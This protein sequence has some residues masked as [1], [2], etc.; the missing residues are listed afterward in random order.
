M[1]TPGLGVLATH[2]DLAGRVAAGWS[3]FDGTANTADCNGHGTHVAGT[4]A[5]TTSGVAKAAT[6]VPVR[7]LDC[8]G[9][10]TLS[11]VIAGIDWAIGHHA[12]GVPAL[13]NLSLGGGT[14]A[15][16]D[17]AVQSLT[18]DGVTVVAAAGNSATD[19]CTTSPA[20]AASAI[21]VAATDTADAQASFSNFGSCV[22]VYAPG[23]S[24]RSAWYTSTTAVQTLSGTSMSAPH[25]A[26]VAAVLLGQ[27]P[28]LTP[29]GVTSALLANATTNVVQRAT[30]G[31]PNRLL[32]AAPPATAA[33]APAPSPTPTA[34]AATA[35]AAPT[36]VTERALT[37]RAAT[38]AWTQ[39]AN[40]GSALTKHT[41]KVFLGSK[42]VGSVAT[43]GT[44][45]SVKVTGL[46]I[47][48]SYTF[49]VNATNAVGT[50][51]D[52]APSNAITALR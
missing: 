35:P 20:R 18:N 40:G 16:L 25:A 32:Y 8:A 31:T 47:G 37:G 10:G 36:A 52:S 6:V 21:T 33:P 15:S 46:T 42:L 4:L 5:G 24:I 3:A 1:P 13:A 27:Q 41:V 38:V 23:V 50:S 19:A 26:G 34:P 48:K 12:A 30:A 11:G 51:R 28:T 44:A 29:A 7:V 45:T 49:R 9:S 2:A 22:D 43:T 17:T 39:G 14:S